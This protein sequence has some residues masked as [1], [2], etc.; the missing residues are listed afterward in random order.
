LHF[1]FDGGAANLVKW[2]VSERLLPTGSN[3]RTT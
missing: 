2:R 3:C 1:K